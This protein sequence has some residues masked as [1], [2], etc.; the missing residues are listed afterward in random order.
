[1]NYQK[2]DAPLA[3]A[4]SD[5]QN[6]EEP[7]FV[8]FIHTEAN[9]DPT[10]AAF[11]ESLGISDAT[12]QAS[13]FTATLSPSKIAQLSEKSWVKYLKLSQKLRLVGRS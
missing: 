13:V 1:M 5:V 4:L 6:P 12:S 10:D 7:C 8:V 2:L 3:M 11:L 9:P